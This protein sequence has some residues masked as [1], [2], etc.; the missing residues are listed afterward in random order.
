M[1]KPTRLRF[2]GAITETKDADGNVVR[3]EPD[4]WYEGVPARDLD[5]SDLASFDA[6]QIKVLTGPQAGGG[7]PLY[8]DDSPADESAKADKPAAEKGKGS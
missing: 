1:A 5:E 3:R 4:R 7:K 2:V 6:A 8:V